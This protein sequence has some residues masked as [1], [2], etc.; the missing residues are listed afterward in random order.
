MSGSGGISIG[1]WIGIV[2]GAAAAFVLIVVVAN[3]TP[4]P[5]PRE[6]PHLY[7]QLGEFINEPIIIEAGGNKAFR[8]DLNRP[9]RIRGGFIAPDPNT[10]I[11]FFV[12]TED[13]HKIWLENKASEKRETSTGYVRQGSF[14]H[15]VEP[16]VYYI[17][18]DNAE[19][20]D[21]EV[22]VDVIINLERP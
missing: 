20:P 5:V 12:F 10:R 8:I 11:G 22:S 16:R 4:P 9:A 17:V 2:A 14:D 19:N 13:D 7:T 21:R 6:K 15:P 3:N 1:M 18:F